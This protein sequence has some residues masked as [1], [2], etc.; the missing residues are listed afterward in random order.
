MANFCGQCGT[1]LNIKTGT[2]PN[3]ACSEY[4]PVNNFNYKILL[5]LPIVVLFFAGL[6]WGTKSYMRAAAEK[7]LVA[8]AMQAVIPHLETYQKRAEDDY[9]LRERPVILAD[10]DD[11]GLQELLL[12]DW[13]EVSYTD[14]FG[15][16][17][18]WYTIHDYRNGQ[19]IIGK[20][21]EKIESMSFA[22]PQGSVGV[23][24]K[25]NKAYLYKIKW[26]A[27]YGTDQSEGCEE[28]TTVT[29]YDS[30]YLPRKK[31]RVNIT[32]TGDFF[33]SDYKE[34]QEYSVNAKKVSYNQFVE[35][36]SEYDGLEYN[37][38]SGDFEY[39]KEL[40]TVAELINQL[41]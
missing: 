37:K 11:D 26:E 22:A 13:G 14:E 7:A 16:M 41:Q 36:L 8:E 21:T 6:L 24:Y 33:G 40:P 1:R 25:D 12:H 31:F 32:W 18:I 38:T 17:A 15:D 3:T 30:K 20:G 10:F 19:W 9:I 27:P 23:V 5:L 2:C 29:I 28:I 34:H 35:E 4:V 39:T